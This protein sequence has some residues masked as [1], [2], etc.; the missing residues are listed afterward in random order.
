MAPFVPFTWGTQSRYLYL[1][2]IGFAMLLADGVL[3][4]DRLLASIVSR[5]AGVA[6]AV[7]LTSAI[8]VRFIAFALDNV[9]TFAARTETYRRYGELFRQVHGP[10]P[11]YSRVDPDDR[12]RTD[13]EP[14]FVTAMIQWEYGDPTIELIARDERER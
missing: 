10:L 4:F 11:R 8:A 9:E 2:A 6:A 13:H 5:K 1:P 7:L 12:L 14:R 3:Y